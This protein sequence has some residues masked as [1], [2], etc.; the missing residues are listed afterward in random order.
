M[1]LTDY[2]KQVFGNIYFAHNNYGLFVISGRTS[3][4]RKFLLSLML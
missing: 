1:T 3:I 4:T 2:Y